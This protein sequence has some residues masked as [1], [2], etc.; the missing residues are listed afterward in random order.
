MKQHETLST[1]ERFVNWLTQTLSRYRKVITIGG[2]TAVVLI[3]GIVA[4]FEIQDRRLEESLVLVEQAEE[5]IQQLQALEEGD[6]REQ[7]ESDVLATLDEVIDGY[8]R[9]YS[10]QRALFLRGSLRMEQE[11]WEQAIEDFSRVSD[12]FSESH[13]AL[14]SLSNKAA[15]YEELGNLDQALATYE[16]LA[17]KRE[18][19]NPLRARALFSIGRIQEQMGDT[20]AAT[21][22]YEQLVSEYSDSEWTNLARN[23]ILVL[24]TGASAN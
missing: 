7:M 13:L 3:V 24:E 20:E 1:R 8:S 14:I 21:T 23:R 12:E 2:I 15:A 19:R 17:D 18:E 6:E 9:L 16:E 10:A 11:A 22:S 5:Q 4:Y